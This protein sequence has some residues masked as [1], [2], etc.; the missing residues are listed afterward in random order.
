MANAA[1]AAETV[2]HTQS[3]ANMNE[4]ETGL[5]PTAV[6]TINSAVYFS[7]NV[8]DGLEELDLDF[9]LN[10]DVEERYSEM[11]S[12]DV[13]DVLSL[14]G[15]SFDDFDIEDI[16]LEELEAAAAERGFDDRELQ[17]VME[18]DS[19]IKTVAEASNAETQVLEG[20]VA[21]SA[22]AVCVA[23]VAVVAAAVG[24][25]VAAAVNTTVTTGSY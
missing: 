21:C 16:D 14:Q 1:S 5:D 23:V 9:E 15:L 17:T 19:K 3:V 4:F 2:D 6:E 8:E 7:G 24:A 22:V 10:E 12:G 18:M 25:T 13:D 11:L 20:H